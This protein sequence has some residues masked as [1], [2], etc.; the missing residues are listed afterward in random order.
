MVFRDIGVCCY[1]LV[2]IRLVVPGLC[3]SFLAFCCWFWILGGGA[4]EIAH[5]LKGRS[6]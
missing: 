1:G 3:C 6:D 2:V 5:V 4:V